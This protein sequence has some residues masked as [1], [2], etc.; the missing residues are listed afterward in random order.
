[1]K[2][3]PCIQG[4]P[5]TED[6]VRG[7]FS[8]RANCGHA[9][10]NRAGADSQGALASSATTHAEAIAGARGIQTDR[11]IM[12]NP[13]SPFGFHIVGKTNSHVELHS[14]NAT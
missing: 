8:A 13:L 14:T 3:S 12:P 5:G 11:R 10:A 6:R 4:E 7:F 2:M 9:G 1:M